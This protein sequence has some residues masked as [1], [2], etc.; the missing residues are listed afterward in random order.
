MQFH[1][2]VNRNEFLEMPDTE[3]KK[4]FRDWRK[5]DACPWYVKEQYLEDNGQHARGGAGPAGKKRNVQENGSGALP[6]DEYDAKI[7]ALLHAQDF[8]GAAVLQ[9]QQRV[10]LGEVEPPLE[11]VIDEDATDEGSETEHSSSAEEKEDKENDRET[12]VLK[13]LYKGN[14]EEISRREQQEKSAKVYNRKHNYYRNTRCTCM[15]QEEQ[16]AIPAGVFNVY[17][18]SDD[19]D[20]YLGEQRELQKEMQELLAAKDWINQKGWD[21]ASEAQ[22]VSPSSGKTIDLRLDWAMVEQKL[23]QGYG[24]LA[25]SDAGDVDEVKVLSDFSLDKLD[26][27]QRVFADRVLKWGDELVDVHETVKRDGRGMV[28]DKDHPLHGVHGSSSVQ[29]R[30]WGAHGMLSFPDLSQCRLQARA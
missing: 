20:A 22:V 18:D 3:V 14:M 1:P 9:H 21:V 25:V 15:A 12:Q 11:N 23:K 24:D 10:A 7:D 17:E 4:F 30:V 16:S 26:P 6:P 29:Y 8:T 5:T 2:W 28:G 27:T 13:M 19:E